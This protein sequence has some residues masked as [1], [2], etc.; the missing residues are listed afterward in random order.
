[1]TTKKSTQQITNEGARFV[2]GQLK[3][4]KILVG[5]FD[6]FISDNSERVIV[7]RRVPRPG[8]GVGRDDY[9]PNN[10]LAVA[11]R[12]SWAVLGGRGLLQR[13]PRARPLAARRPPCR[14][15]GRRRPRTCALPL[16]S[17][18]YPPGARKI[19]VSGDVSGDDEKPKRHSRIDVPGRSMG[20]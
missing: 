15:P 16:W 11:W 20:W 12:T 9:A 13:A 8:R 7:Y 6:E 5:Y 10:N 19:R 3:N 14:Q 17:H 2:L 4:S 18:L 1:M